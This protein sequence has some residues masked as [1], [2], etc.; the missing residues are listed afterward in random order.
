[1]VNS[2]Q[3][4]P[5]RSIEFFTAALAKLVPLPSQTNFTR[6]QFSPDSLGE[7]ELVLR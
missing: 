3:L 4:L 2:S 1:L 6:W 5:N 7:L